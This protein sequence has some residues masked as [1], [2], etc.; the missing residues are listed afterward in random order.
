VNSS[1]DL[2]TVLDTIVAK[3]V[4]LSGTDAGTI[5]PP[6][7]APDRQGKK[8]FPPLCPRGNAFEMSVQVLG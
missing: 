1:L 3:A 5:G 8:A 6:V 2:E 7:A 4:Q